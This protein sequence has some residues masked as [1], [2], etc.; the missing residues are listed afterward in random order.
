[1]SIRHTLGFIWLMTITGAMV[2]SCQMLKKPLPD[3]PPSNK[4]APCKL[5]FVL[6]PPPTLPSVPQLTVEQA[7]D[8]NVSDKILVDYIGTIRQ[9][10]RT[11]QSKVTASYNGY[12]KSCR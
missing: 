11:W 9:I 2:S 4:T 6:P 1:M 5:V 10:N 12:R 8:R 3:T 7:A